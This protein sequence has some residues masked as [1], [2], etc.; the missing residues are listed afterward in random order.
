MSS[1]DRSGSSDEIA[2]YSLLVSGLEPLFRIG[3]PD[4]A[5]PRRAH[6]RGVIGNSRLQATATKANG[7]R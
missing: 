4:H 6:V 1:F 2:D 5:S 3:S 7:N